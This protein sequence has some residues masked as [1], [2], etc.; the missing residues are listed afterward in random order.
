L[1]EDQTTHLTLVN[2]TYILHLRFHP[3]DLHPTIL[4]IDC[5]NAWKN[6]PQDK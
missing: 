6:Q 2:H 1:D 4:S 3:L 5:E